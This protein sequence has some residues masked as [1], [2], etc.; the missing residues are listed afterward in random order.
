MIKPYSC[1]L[2]IRAG[3]GGEDDE[4]YKRAVKVLFFT[5]LTHFLRMFMQSF[6][7]PSTLPQVGLKP[8]LPKTGTLTDMENM[9]LDKKLA[10]LR[11]N[12]LLKCMNKHEVLNEHE[13]TWQRNGL[14]DLQYE[15][16]SRKYLDTDGHCSRI[17]VDVQ[18]NKHWTDDRAGINDSQL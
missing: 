14:R 7:S 15:E 6:Y 5:Y 13:A 8:L 16:I 1:T 17:T 3:W 18:L 10:F 11:T 4:L 2:Y 9:N 12:K